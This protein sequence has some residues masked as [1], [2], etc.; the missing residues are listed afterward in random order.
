MHTPAIWSGFKIFEEISYIDK[1]DEKKSETLIVPGQQ[2]VSAF[3]QLL[4]F[5]F[6]RRSR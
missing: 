2:M 4:Q 5:Q 6:L 3:S 1:S